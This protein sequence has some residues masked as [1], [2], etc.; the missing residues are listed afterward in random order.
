M[1]TGNRSIELTIYEETPDQSRKE[2]HD[3]WVSWSEHNGFTATDGADRIVYTSWT[4]DNL[5]RGILNKE[6]KLA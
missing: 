3:V 4:W 6:V 5:M 2:M 1:T